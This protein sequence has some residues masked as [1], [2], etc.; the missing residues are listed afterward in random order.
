M[1]NSTP[2]GRLPAVLVFLAASSALASAQTI[3]I[4]SRTPGGGSPNGA[5][6]G[7]P[8]LSSDGRH[9][10]FRTLATDLAPGGSGI[11]ALDRTT[12]TFERLS[13]GTGG[14]GYWLQP[15]VGGVSDDGRYVTFVATDFVPPGGNDYGSDVLVRD[16]VLNTTVELTLFEFEGLPKTLPEITADGQHVCWWEASPWIP[17]SLTRRI[18]VKTLAGATVAQLRENEPDSLDS[19]DLAAGGRYVAYRHYEAGVSSVRRWDYIASSTL[20]IA[21]TG[22]NPKVLLAPLAISRDGRFVAYARYVFQ[23][24]YELWLHDVQTSTEERIDLPNSGTTHIIRDASVSDDGRYVLWSS[25]APTYVTDDTNNAWD[26]FARDRVIQRTARVSVAVTG[27]QANGHSE[28]FALD[29]AGNALVF[30]TDAPNLVPNDGNSFV[31]VYRRSLCTL[32]YE[33]LDTDGY[34]AGSALFSCAPPPV[35]HVSVGGDC[36]DA[37]PSV[38]PG[39]TEVCNGVD[40]DCDA[41]VDEDVAGVAFCFGDGSGTPCPCGNAG[42]AGNG[43]AS[44]VNAS[45]ARVGTLGCASLSNDTLGLAGSGMSESFALY[46][47]GDAQLGGGS[48]TAF[49]DGLR[50]V[51]GTVARLGTQQNVG[52]ASQYPGTG[53]PSISVQGSVTAPGAR[54]YQT[55][56]R[57]AAGFCT[58]ATFNLTNGVAV[59]WTP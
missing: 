24:G 35:N 6:E 4:L 49:G 58:S 13:V 43:C 46:F 51:G 2:S 39:A 50:C 5:C 22:G 1:P 3:E 56:Y 34:G 42:A 26:V 28:D 59:T 15:Q 52:G 23:L 19:P 54:H 55:W 10:V 8:V 45:G 30:M 53:D 48:G 25:R 14:A 32:T 44:S 12:Q 31:D 17:G 33:D 20:T 27:A 16:R 36:N 57:N 41:S 37:N 21:S 18:V 29:Q 9:V 40:D 7:R 11:V 38:H 47:Q